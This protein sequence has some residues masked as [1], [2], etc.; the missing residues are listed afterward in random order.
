MI[1]IAVLGCDQQGAPTPDRYVPR[2]EFDAKGKTIDSLLAVIDELRNG[3]P[4]SLARAQA[5]WTR[6]DRAGARQEASQLLAKHPEAPEATTAQA[7]L[8]QADAADS[9]DAREARHAEEVALA[10]MRK[11]RDEMRHITFWR[12]R[13]APAHVNDR[14]AVAMYIMQ[15][16]QGMPRLRM[17]IYFKSDEWLFIQRY[18][19]KVDGTDFDFTP[20]TYGDEAVER[21][22]GYG[23]IWEWWDTPAEGQVLAMLHALA[24]SKQATMRYEGRQYYHDRTIGPEERAALRRTFIAYQVLAK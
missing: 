15:P 14:S 6:G 2:A 1:L 21:D 24:D 3:A 22:N 13:A 23:G 9:A 17:V 10:G 19:F 11:N 4:Q 20:N 8:A 5:A 16:D 12:D 18:M 7:I